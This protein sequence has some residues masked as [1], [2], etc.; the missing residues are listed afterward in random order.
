[1]MKH[2]LILTILIITCS[3]SEEAPAVNTEL[4]VNES[5]KEYFDRLPQIEIGYE[6]G[7]NDFIET[8]KIE[9][10]FVPE[11]A[12]VLGKLGMEMKLFHILYV[13][14]ADISLP[15]WEAYDSEGNKWGEEQL[16]DLGHCSFDKPHQFS[17]FEVTA[18]CKVLIKNLSVLGQDTI[19]DN[20][21]IV[22]PLMFHLPD[23][24]DEN[25][26]VL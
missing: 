20:H 10:E 2:L 5:F 1:M 18:R 15:I 3:C 26:P 17:T 19:L 24:T 12:K 21:K 6:I 23:E 4:E 9:S 14:P 11:G 7:S 8:I 13:Y 25:F 16:F 22:N